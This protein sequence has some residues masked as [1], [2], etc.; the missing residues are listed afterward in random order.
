MLNLDP[1]KCIFL[2]VGLLVLCTLN[3]H[4]DEKKTI[5]MYVGIIS[6]IL[7]G[8]ILL[9]YFMNNRAIMNRMNDSEMNYY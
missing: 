8:I 6:L 3:L 2:V 1:S 7:V 9:M 5:L 4:A